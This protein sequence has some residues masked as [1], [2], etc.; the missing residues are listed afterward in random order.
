MALALEYTNNELP[1][2]TDV[3]KMAKIILCEETEPLSSSS[4][5]NEPEL[6][7]ECGPKTCHTE[8]REINENAREIRKKRLE[9][10]SASVKKTRRVLTPRHDN[11]LLRPIGWKGDTPTRLPTATPKSRPRRNMRVVE[12]NKVDLFADTD[13]GKEKSAAEEESDDESE[14]MS[15]FIVDDSE[16]IEEDDS[17]IETGPPPPRSV[18]RFLKGRKLGTDKDEEREGLEIKMRTLDITDPDVKSR[19]EDS[20]ENDTGSFRE[21]NSEVPP[22]IM[23]YGRSTKPARKAEVTKGTES[24]TDSGMDKIFIQQS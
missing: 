20:S 18:K 13:E 8:R 15:D 24:E 10:L 22:Q 7:S 3:P 19:L 17:D 4:T 5:T 16:S 6:V 9:A 11:P 12:E 23:D 14:G 1:E 21:E 2:L